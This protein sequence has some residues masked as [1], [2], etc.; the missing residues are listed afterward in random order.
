ML[1]EGKVRA[2]AASA[3]AALIRKT[4]P[5][6]SED[7]ISSAVENVIRRMLENGDLTVEGSVSDEQIAEAV[8]AYLADNPAK[9]DP[10]K[11]AYQYAKDGGY[12]G[13]E[14][15]FA[16]KLAKEK[17]V[18]PYPITIN[19]ETYDGSEPVNIEVASLFEE[20][21]ET[22]E[23][24]TLSGIPEGEPIE[25]VTNFG[26]RSTNKVEVFHTATRNLIDIPAMLGGTGSTFT[27]S[28][29]TATANDDGTITISGANS[30][31]AE[32][33][34]ISI[35]NDNFYNRTGNVTFPAGSYSIGGNK[36]GCY[37]V[38]MARTA[39]GTIKSMISGNIHTFTEAWTPYMYQVKVGPS[40]SGEI[41]FPLGIW[42]GSE[43]ELED[44]SYKGSKY[45]MTLPSSVSS[46]SFNWNTGEI[47]DTSGG[48]VS[49]VTPTNIVSKAKQNNLFSPHESLTATGTKFLLPDGLG[50]GSSTTTEAPFDPTEWGLPVINLKNPNGVNINKDD[51]VELEYIHAK[52]SGTCQ[53]KWQGSSSLLYPKH[54]YT[55]KFDAAF[56]ATDIFKAADLWD[57]T[58]GVKDSIVPWGAQTKYCL[59]ADYMEPS[60]A[61]NVVCAKLWGQIV[62]SRAGVSSRLSAL[63]NGGAIDG[64][65]VIVTMDG[66]F[67]GLYNFNIPKDGWMFGMGSGTQ[68]AIVCA[69]AWTSATAFG[70]LATL[71]GDFELEY[72][73]DEDNSS[74]VLESINRLISAVM[75]SDG[76][77]IDTVIAQYMDIK[78]A[79]DFFDFVAL[80]GGAD[81]VGK[82]YILYTLDGVKWGFS[83]YDMDTVLGLKATGRH[84]YKATEPVRPD[85]IAA[86]HRLFGLLKTH[87]AAELKARYNELRAGVLSESNVAYMFSE[88]MGDIPQPVYIKDYET[89]PMRPSTAVAGSI[90][91][92][93]DWYRMRVQ[94]IDKDIESL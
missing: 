63:P 84:F 27:V 20:V 72:V 58:D 55:I 16:A 56:E 23:Y 81:M 35:A 38:V 91:Q 33:T 69:D 92:I 79:I 34:L 39:S 68:E 10:G 54:N 48:V 12:A 31:G 76:S 47:K 67:H 86:M 88:Y 57:S 93:L 29:V 25:V 14:A 74:W 94:V 3:A 37:K 45:T 52:G 40:F 77:D 42:K 13:T 41:V 65:P 83:A 62:K 87:K 11:S 21:T 90:G 44:Y 1:T 17:F 80:I 46:G 49:T 36:N 64:F 75:T 51:Y 43:M 24:V 8:E 85:G 59:K 2:I 22:G 70:A 9:G 7:Q 53:I 5:N 71:N 28:G 78:S 61:R 66:K 32:F 60:S 26:A 15:D 30:S 73:S 19:G 82:N 89:Y 18:N 4:A 6:V 50:G